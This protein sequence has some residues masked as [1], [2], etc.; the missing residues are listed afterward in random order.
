M[1]PPLKSPLRREDERLLTGRARYVDNVH[2]DRM[3]HGVFIRSPMAHAEIVSI[4]VDAAL[5]AGALCVL[6][7]RDLP[8]NDKPWVTRYWHSSIRDGMPKFLPFDRVR[9][10]GEPLLSW[11][12]AIV[13]AQ[14]ISPPWCI[15]TISPFPFSPRSR[16]RLLSTRH[17]SIPAGPETSRPNS[18]MCRVIRSARWRQRHIACVAHLASSARRRSRLS[19]EVLSPNSTKP[20]MD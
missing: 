4:D 10:V 12:P 11:W 13:T 8:F 14:R 15:L 3:V 7:A 9:F 19:R 17:S 20:A 16:T 5:A 18:N 2:L 1:N 6:T